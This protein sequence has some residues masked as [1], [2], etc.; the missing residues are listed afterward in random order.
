MTPEQVKTFPG[1]ISRVDFGFVI[2]K[3]LQRPKTALFDAFKF[4]LLGLTRKLPNRTG[5]LR[6]ARKAVGDQAIVLL[7]RISITYRQ[8]FDTLP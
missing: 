3:K 6:S 4:G 8:K 5:G 2:Y 1:E 7:K